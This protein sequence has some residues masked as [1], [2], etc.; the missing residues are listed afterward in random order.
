MFAPLNRRQD[1]LTRAMIH[2]II[3]N[4]LKKRK[5]SR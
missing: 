3:R 5:L 2:K 1:G 4:R